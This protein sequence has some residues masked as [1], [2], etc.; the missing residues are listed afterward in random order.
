MDFLFQDSSNVSTDRQKGIPQALGKLELPSKRRDKELITLR[1][2]F[3][4]ASLGRRNLPLRKSHPIL[5][6]LSL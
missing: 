6:S 1:I 3:F 2:S 4:Q 5:L